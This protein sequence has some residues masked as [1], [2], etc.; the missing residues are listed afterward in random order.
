MQFRDGEEKQLGS[1]TDGRIPLSS[2]QREQGRKEGFLIRGDG[3]KAGNRE[4][5]R[6]LMARP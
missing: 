6:E 2:F 1:T 3:W 5:D 4:S